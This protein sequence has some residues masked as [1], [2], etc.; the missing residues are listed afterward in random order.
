MRWRLLIHPPAGAAHNM[1]VDETLYL[2]ARS[3]GQATVR[4]YGFAEPTVSLGFRQ[5]LEDAVNEEACRRNGVGLVRRITGGRALLHQHELTWSVTA[6]T[7]FGAFRGLSVR[8]AYRRVNGAIRRACLELGLHLDPETTSLRRSPSRSEEADGGGGLPCLAAPSPHEITVAGRKLVPSA[9]RRHRESLLQHGSILFSVDVELWNRIR[10]ER[11]S[12][13]LNAV[14]L[15]ELLP[16]PPSSTGWVEGLR[17]S[18]ADL[19]GEE[20][21]VPSGLGRE[22]QTSIER[23]ER[24]YA[25]EAHLRAP[26]YIDNSE[27]VW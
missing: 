13:A 5:E 19:F 15:E 11:G 22:E 4:L 3:S 24:K 23:L 8:D 6:P 7:R 21:T 2:S 10:P 1:A 9:Q 25:S 27:A 20:A 14:G 12:P 26:R 17:R 16:T 18:F